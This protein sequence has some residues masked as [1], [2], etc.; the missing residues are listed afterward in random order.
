MERQPEVY[1][2]AVQSAVS[3]ESGCGNS[4]VTKPSDSSSDGPR[5]T[6]NPRG[7]MA[8]T[9]PCLH[10]RRLPTSAPVT[11]PLAIVFYEKL[12]PGS[13]VVNRLTDLGYRVTATQLASEVPRLARAE[14]PMV[15]VAD[16]QLRAGDFVSVIQT[17]KSSADTEHVPILGYCDP[18]N[19]KL[20]D[21]AVKAG[22][23]LVAAEKGLPEQLPQLLD[24]VLA[25]E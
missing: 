8:R 22:A 19:Q 14:S 21:A 2:P 3:A 12:L 13:Q 20:V 6:E 7:T 9:A 23:K 11:K 17:L 16:L 5:S 24:H 10:A 1:G 25:V 15:I 4:R 18:K